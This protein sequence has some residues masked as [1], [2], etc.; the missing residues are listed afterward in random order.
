[1]S[2]VM[3]PRMGGGVARQVERGLGKDHLHDSICQLVTVLA[4][5]IRSKVSLH[6]HTAALHVTFVATK[7]W[8]CIWASGGRSR[9]IIDYAAAILMLLSSPWTLFSV[10]VQLCAV[11]GSVGAGLQ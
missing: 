3:P 4:M 8:Y 9:H 10:H 7:Q 1:M 6:L 2:L 5:P 11:L